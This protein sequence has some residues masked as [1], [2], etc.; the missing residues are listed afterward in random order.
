MVF[1]VKIGGNSP[2]GPG[3]PGDEDGNVKGLQRDRLQ[4]DRLRETGD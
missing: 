2:G 3:G 4:T 1:D